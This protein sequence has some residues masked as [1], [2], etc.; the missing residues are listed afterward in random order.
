MAIEIGSEARSLIIWGSRTK[1]QGRGFVIKACPSC[2]GD[3]VHF[4]A[5]SKT[6][7]TLY[8]VPTFTTSTKA[9]LVCTQ[10]EREE[11]VGGGEAE[12]YLRAALPPELI[13]AGLEQ[14]EGP[15]AGQAQSPAHSLAVG[16][17]VLA[18]QVS[19]A[20]G[21]I[22]DSEAA[23]IGQGF[24]TIYSATESEPVKQAAGLAVASLGDLIDWIRA[25]STGPVDLMLASAGRV[26][27]ELKSADRSRYIG[28]VAWLGD[29]VSG[30]SF[31]STE[32]CLA[33]MDTGLT[34]M[35]FDAHEVAEAL[36]FCDANGG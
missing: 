11:E 14:G 21:T 5:E 25:P 12:A 20:D 23:A 27:R 28:Q 24:A 10:C 15:T 8:F 13:R 22:D 30:T 16:M 34:L 3:Q 32:A 29:T 6:K 19:L 4:V 35:G 18:L 26:A 1:R 17:V 31:G 2:R 7:F 33:Q 9:L 36:T